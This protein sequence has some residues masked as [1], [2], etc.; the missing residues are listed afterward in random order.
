[1]NIKISGTSVQLLHVLKSKTFLRTQ[2][3][4]LV[5]KALKISRVQNHAVTAAARTLLLAAS[6]WLLTGRNNHAGACTLACSAV[7]IIYH[8]NN[9]TYLLFCFGGWETWEN[10]K[11]AILW[12]AI[13]NE[14]MRRFVLI[15]QSHTD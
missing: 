8:W 2:T 5:R 13:E 9:L 7:V 1:M 15:A 6:E 10:S 12:G 11:R 4:F 3:V 14:N